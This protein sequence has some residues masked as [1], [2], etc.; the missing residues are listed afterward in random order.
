MGKLKLRKKKGFDFRVFFFILSKQCT[1]RNHIPLSKI[2]LTFL[3]IIQTF[4][5]EYKVMNALLRLDF[6]SNNN[7]YKVTS[8][9]IALQKEGT[10]LV[11]KSG[12]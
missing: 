3:D 9:E 11:G 2:I 6:L 5:M 12:S 10:T 8:P 4:C 1:Y 7:N